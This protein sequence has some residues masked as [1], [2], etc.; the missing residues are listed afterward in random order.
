MKPFVILFAL[1]IIQTVCQAQIDFQPGDYIRNDGAKTS[2]LIK[3]Y[4]WL[5]NPTFI[6]CKRLSDASPVA[7]GMDSII[8]VGV[9][10]AKYQRIEVDVETSG[11][12]TDELS[13]SPPSLVLLP[14]CPTLFRSGTMQKACPGSLLLI[15]LAK[16]LSIRTIMRRAPKR[17]FT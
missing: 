8:E 5:K 15:T 16:S 14:T 7:I 6:N 13:R 12:S 3:D 11:T 1:T 2:C 4:G 10:G 9:G 17:S